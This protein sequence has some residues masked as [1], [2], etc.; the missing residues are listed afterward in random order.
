MAL[1][2]VN[3]VVKSI[4][5]KAETK[6]KEEQASATISNCVNQIEQNL[7]KSLLDRILKNEKTSIE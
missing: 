2:Y 7:K 5:E 1:R 6:W 3:N 4:F